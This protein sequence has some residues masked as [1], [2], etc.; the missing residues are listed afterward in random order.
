M[1]GATT[2]TDLSTRYSI[3]VLPDGHVA[4]ECYPESRFAFYLTPQQARRLG[5]KL[6]KAS[7][8]WSEQD[9][10]TMVRA[11]RKIRDASLWQAER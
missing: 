3:D 7:G 6:W 2:V 11:L 4:V 8:P 9:W 1:A 10:Q 5:T